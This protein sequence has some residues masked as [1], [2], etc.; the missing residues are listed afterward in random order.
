VTNTNTVTQQD[1][2]QVHLHYGS[3]EFESMLK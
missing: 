3:K 2:I 1:H